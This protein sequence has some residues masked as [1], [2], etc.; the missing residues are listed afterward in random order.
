MRIT[1]NV[2][3]IDSEQVLLRLVLD[4]LC[5]LQCVLSHRDLSNQELVGEC[6][7]IMQRERQKT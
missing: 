5:V 1:I 6:V 4:V 3:E 2:L 7:R